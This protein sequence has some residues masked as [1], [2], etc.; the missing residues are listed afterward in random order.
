MLG[1][2]AREFEVRWMNG[3][4]TYDFSLL[5][6]SSSRCCRSSP[7]CGEWKT[8]VVMGGPAIGSVIILGSA[9]D[10]LHEEE[11]FA[12]GAILADLSYC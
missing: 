12:F 8:R 7:A 6:L 2:R 4:E 1:I 10:W 3:R 9:P 5:M 11:R